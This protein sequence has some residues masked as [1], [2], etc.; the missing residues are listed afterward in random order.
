MNIDKA[1][2]SKYLKAGDVSETPRAFTITHAEIEEVGRDKEERLVLYFVDQD[3]GM[4]V[5]KTNANTIAKALGSKE[6]DEWIGKIIRLYSTEVQFGDEMVE[7]IRVSLKPGR[8]EKPQFSKKELQQPVNV[9]ADDA[10]VSAAEM[11]SKPK[12]GD[13]DYNVPGKQKRDWDEEP[14]TADNIPF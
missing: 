2:P 8:I 13:P 1:Y 3:K 14:E 10:G 12:K 11:E 6:T 9:E 5:N 4:V 7:A